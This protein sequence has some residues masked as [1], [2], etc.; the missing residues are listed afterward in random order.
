MPTTPPQVVLQPL[1][2]A[3]SDL[4]KQFLYLA[5]HVPNGRP[6]PFDIIDNDPEIKRYWDGF[7]SQIGDIGIMAIDTKT[8][9]V[10]GCAWGRALPKDAP[11]FG[12]LADDIPEVGLAL[13]P[14]YQRK[15]IG[16]ALLRTLLAAYASDPNAPSG[17]GW[18]QISLSTTRTNKVA[19]QVYENLGFRIVKEDDAGDLL[20]VTDLDPQKTGEPEQVGSG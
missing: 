2:P 1:P 8:A 3:R 11:G 12:Y 4:L 6:L 10:I 18:Q 5:I 20:M 9:E 14:E 17:T 7:G 15:G 13:L 19:Q 16:T